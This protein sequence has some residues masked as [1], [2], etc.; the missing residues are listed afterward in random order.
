VSRWDTSVL[1]SASR[2]ASGASR[3]AAETLTENDYSKASAILQASFDSRRSNLRSKDSNILPHI[4]AQER[5]VYV[6]DTYEKDD[7][8]IMASMVS[9]AKTLDYTVSKLPYGDRA[10][11]TP[12]DAMW[13]IA[14]GMGFAPLD[15]GNKFIIKE[16]NDMYE[17]GRTIARAQQLLGYF[18]SE[19]K[20]GAEALRKDQMFFGNNPSQSTVVGKVNYPVRYTGKMVDSCF[21]EIEWASYLAPMYLVL[22]RKSWKLLDEEI[23]IS[24]AKDVMLQY[25]EVLDLFAKRET[26]IVPQKGRTAAV[27]IRKVPKKPKASSLLKKTESEILERSMTKVFAAIDQSSRDDWYSHV[28]DHG[29]SAIKRKIVD[30]ANVRTQILQR[31][32]AM[33]TKRLNEL[34]ASGDHLKTVRK[35]DVQST[36]LNTMLLRRE[37]PVERFA[38]EIIS[39]DPTFSSI[40]VDFR[41]VLEDGTVNYNSSRQQLINLLASK[42]LYTIVLDTSDPFDFDYNKLI[43]GPLSNLYQHNKESFIGQVALLLHSKRIKLSDERDLDV[44]INSLKSYADKK[45]I[46]KAKITQHIPAWVGLLHKKHPELAELVQDCLPK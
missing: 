33:T 28:M 1:T 17:F 24:S 23:L 16:K 44:I 32:A 46:E 12:A 8:V 41:V 18:N 30:N 43:S 42:N 4:D 31:F 11:E 38:D 6:P 3:E 37:K 34:R 5:I 25:T 29:F 10:Y 20:L 26:V 7:N 13:Q 15:V 14:T 22:L 40:L 27:S 9:L 36:D 45:Q 19:K 2:K 35:R 21:A 39:I